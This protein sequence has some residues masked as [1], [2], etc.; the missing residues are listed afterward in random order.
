LLMEAVEYKANS[1]FPVS[2][3]RKYPCFSSIIL[4]PIR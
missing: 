3:T 4:A 2:V 1:F